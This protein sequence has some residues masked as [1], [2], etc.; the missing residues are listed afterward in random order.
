LITGSHYAAPY[1]QLGNTARRLMKTAIPASPAWP[2]TFASDDER[3]QWLRRLFNTTNN[4]LELIEML[5]FYWR[6]NQDPEIL[7][8]AKARLM[9]LIT[10]DPLGASSEKNQDQANRNIYM[11]L[12][13]GYDLIGSELTNADRLRLIDIFTKRVTAG[14][15]SLDTLD[16][17]PYD[18]HNNTGIQTLMRALLLVSG[19]RGFE[20]TDAFLTKVW[21]LF[22]GQFQVYGGEDGG[23]D[24]SV[25]Y[26]W[27]DLQ[28]TSRGL[29]TLVLTT[30]IDLSSRSYVR[31]MGDF[32][33]AMTLPNKALINAFGDGLSDSTLYTKNNAGYQLYAAVTR[34]PQHEWYW[35]QD[36]NSLSNLSYI[37]PLHY[38]LMG[39]KLPTII[40]VAPTKNDFVFD[41]VGL[42]AMHN[43]AASNNRSS[44]MFRSSPIGSYAH[45]HADQNS[46][47]LISNG[48]NLLINS[49][50]Y[51]WYHSRHHLMSRSTRYKN[52]VT[53]DGG[54]GQAEPVF[55]S[56]KPASP[57]HSMEA[58][59]KIINA[60]MG[61]SVSVV[62]GDATAAYSAFDA[63][64]FTWKPT[65]Q[66]AYRSVAYFK[67][68]GVV[69]VYDW[70]SSSTPRQWELNYH[71]IDPFTINGT[72]LVANN[73]MVR[74][75]IT[76][77]GINGTLSTNNKFEVPAE[78]GMPEQGHA[79][80]TASARSTKAVVVTLIKENCSSARV[81]VV[82]SGDSAFV[83]LGTH[84][85]NMERDKINMI[86]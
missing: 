22:V 11:A 84:A 29:A 79:R 19:T 5:G 82:F 1:S 45:A 36:P 52:A 77:H 12:A 74:G 30:G 53:F 62:T 75:C 41:D 15:A 55:A 2:I 81:D 10:W 9:N 85:V 24:G 39:R 21:P 66:G 27:Y 37:T 40:P 57:M 31:N 42:V 69:A 61:D 72:T 51:P 16:A 54:L 78:K 59:G 58:Q 34:Q 25:A 33:I 7:T 13:I 73:G 76:H 56:A 43:R 4:E 6:F 70:L 48:V 63:A 35:R 26:A 28:V 65:L 64:S 71:G 60:F 38:M 86:R 67:S 46:F 18:T 44:V 8:A 3:S 50:H 20:K 32:L 17:M 49:G 83:L 23:Y 80:F 14:I 47:T 68:E